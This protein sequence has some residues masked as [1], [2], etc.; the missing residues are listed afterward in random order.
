MTA[1][2]IRNWIIKADNDIKIIEHELE[3]PESEWITD[4]I[5]FHCQQAAEKYM[6]VLLIYDNKDIPKTHNIEFLQSLLK[7]NH[8]DLSALDV[9]DISLF[10]VDVR[11]PDNFYQPTIDE[12]KYY[13]SLVFRIKELVLKRIPDYL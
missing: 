11:Y 5:C 10:G 3:L 7:E 2:Y 4:V 13:T 9:K 1:D 8:P 12:V 6:K